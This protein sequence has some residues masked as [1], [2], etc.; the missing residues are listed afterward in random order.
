M[1]CAAALSRQGT[2][3]EAIAATGVENHVARRGLDEFG[4]SV[5]QRRGHSQIVQAPACGYRRRCVA[6]LLG[7]P[8]LRLQQVNVAAARYI[9]GMSVSAK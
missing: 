5:E 4:D 8:V 6:G 7:A 1:P 3:I 2:K 9:E